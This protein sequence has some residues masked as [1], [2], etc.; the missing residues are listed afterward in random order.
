M[1]IDD[2]SI[3]GTDADGSVNGDYCKYCYEGGEFLHKVTMEEFIDMCSQFGEQA[4]MT[5]EQMREHCRNVFPT[6]L[7]WRK[8]E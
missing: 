4:G 7:R 8:T 1:P 2:D 3:Y 6:L 5:N